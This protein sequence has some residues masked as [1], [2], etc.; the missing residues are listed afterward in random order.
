MNSPSSTGRRP[1]DVTQ[2]K[3]FIGDEEGQDLVEYGLIM[4]VVAL[5]AVAILA[6]LGVNITTFYSAAEAPVRAATK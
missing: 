2:L 5:A 3:H 1:K 6:S 4:C